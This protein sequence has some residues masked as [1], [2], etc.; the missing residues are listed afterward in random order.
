MITLFTTTKAFSGHFA[1]IQR[2]AIKSWQQLSP[3]PEIFVFG[4]EP[5]TAETCREL[6]VRHVPDV[7]PANG[8]APLVRALFHRAEL[9]GSNP[10]LCYINADIILLADFMHA[11][12]AVSRLD[13]PFLMVGRVWR[14]RI[15][16]AIDYSDSGWERAVRQQVARGA[17]Q[18]PPPGNSDY[19]LYRRGLWTDMPPLVLG[20]GFWDPW[21][22]YAARRACASVV[23]A[24]GAVMAIHQDHDQSSY[25]HG[26]RQWRKEINSNRA[27][28]GAARTFTLFDATHQLVDGGV[29][30]TLGFRRAVRFVD[31]IG[32]LHPRLARVLR[33]LGWCLSIVRGFRERRR[34]M[35]DP[36][37]RVMRSVEVLLPPDGVTAID[38]ISS[39]AA[40]RLSRMLLGGGYPTIVYDEDAGAVDAAAR[41]LG[42][43]VEFTASRRDLWKK[44]DVIVV[45][46]GHGRL[47]I[48]AHPREG[49]RPVRS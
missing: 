36:V 40:V 33:P 27:L 37:Y 17:V 2:N 48:Q 6:S 47:A 21:L 43:P 44:A 4:D 35:A 16:H 38:G 25:Q 18:A 5:G 23:D 31:T 15:D 9:L 20:R 41:V 29:R 34:R 46:D 39:P 10:L 30:R 24:S 7:A 32:V 12:V 14:M 3:K 49:A 26:L 13:R 22:I 11:A 1:V 19:F 45:A 8:G 42:G 28:A